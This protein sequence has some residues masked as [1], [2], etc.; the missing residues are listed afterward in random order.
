MSTSLPRST[1]VD[2]QVDP[3]AIL[4]FLDAVDERPGVEMHSLMVV[5][6][7][8]VVA[9]GWWAPGRSR[10]PHPRPRHRGFPDRPVRDS[11]DAAAAAA[12]RLGGRLHRSGTGP[13]PG[14]GPVTPWRRDLV[15]APHGTRLC[16]WLRSPAG[17]A[18]L[19]DADDAEPVESR[20]GSMSCEICQSTNAE[21]PVP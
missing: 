10:L 2:Q 16:T 11:Y 18:P 3:A 6:H 8:R 9:E 4:S 15:S 1:P 12:Q 20:Q 14:P 5:R 13:A 7:G 17:S 21:I 19:L